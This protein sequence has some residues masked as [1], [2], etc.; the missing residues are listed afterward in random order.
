MKTLKPSKHLNTVN[1]M[2]NLISWIPQ[3]ACIPEVFET[4]Q[5]LE[6]LET[7]ET[8]RSNKV[9]NSNQESIPAEAL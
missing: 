3:Q 5:T 4:L 9:A 8:L 1:S 7:L 6:A 2:K